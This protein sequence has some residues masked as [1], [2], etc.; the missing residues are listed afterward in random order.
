MVET[1]NRMRGRRESHSKSQ[2]CANKEPRGLGT[3]KEHAEVTGEI[4]QRVKERPNKFE[5]Y[6]NSMRTEGQNSHC[7][8][9]SSGW[10]EAKIVQGQ[11]KMQAHSSF[12]S[13]GMAG[14]E[15]AA[16]YDK[17]LTTAG[18]KDCYWL[19][20]GDGGIE[21]RRGTD[22]MQNTVEIEK[23]YTSRFK[24]F[25]KQVL[26]CYNSNRADCEIQHVSNESDRKIHNS[27]TRNI[28]LL[29]AEHQIDQMQKM[30]SMSHNSN[31]STSESV[32]IGQRLQQLQE[33]R[34]FHYHPNCGYSY[35]ARNFVQKPGLQSQQRPCGCRPIEPTNGPAIIT[36]KRVNDMD[37][38]DSDKTYHGQETQN[39]YKDPVNNLHRILSDKDLPHSPQLP[40]YLIYQTPENELLQLRLENARSLSNSTAEAPYTYS[41]YPIRLSR[42]HGCEVNHNFVSN[43]AGRVLAGGNNPCSGAANQFPQSQNQRSLHTTPGIPNSLNYSGL[44]EP[45]HVQQNENSSQAARLDKLQSNLQ[46]AR[47]IEASSDHPISRTYNED[48][49]DG[50]NECQTQVAENDWSEES[51]WGGDVGRVF[52]EATAM[53]PAQGR[54]RITN[55]LD[56][57]KYGRNKLIAKYIYNQTGKSRTTKQISS[58][59]QVLKRRQMS[60]ID[61]TSDSEVC[62]S[63]K[64]KSSDDNASSETKI[65]KF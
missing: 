57:K 56:K 47:H 29:T 50:W 35:I 46:N 5:V 54:Y 28:T 52:D 21:Y 11:K 24:E 39:Y 30:K 63:E 49:R 22:Q 7:K 32:K 17:N 44:Q 3:G 1:R 60:G 23:E 43:D 13:Q 53:F 41:S 26:E 16:C 8:F 51:V 25:K 20:H 18:I 62:S 15:K 10:N 42:Q 34:P 64:D 37:Y 45:V 59:V 2:L 65:A 40:Q 58:H 33:K 27:N 38:I 19:N 48:S 4:K 6:Q 55:G 36:E 14:S 61:K 12:D 9:T 31:P